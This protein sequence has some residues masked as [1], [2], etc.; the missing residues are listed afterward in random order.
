M[1]SAIAIAYKTPDSLYFTRPEQKKYVRWI[2]SPEYSRANHPSLNT[3]SRIRNGENDCALVWQEGLAPNR[4]IYYTGL[5][6]RNDSIIY[7]IPNTIVGE[8]VG[9]LGD[10]LTNT[11]TTILKAGLWHDNTMPVVQRIDDNLCY[12]Y[13]P[14]NADYNL[15]RVVWVISGLDSS[16]K[17]MQ[18]NI[19]VW[20]DNPG[21]H[22]VNLTFFNRIFS[23]GKDLIQPSL[24]QGS[25]PS[26]DTVEMAYSG[27]S[28]YVLNFV[29]SSGDF[30]I[31]QMACNTYV[32]SVPPILDIDSLSDD[33][34]YN[35][36]SD[37]FSK[38]SYYKGQKPN[39]AAM[40]F[41]PEGKNWALNRRIFEHGDSTPP[42]IMASMDLFARKSTLDNDYV[43]PFFGF[44][45][46]DGKSK[47]SP[48]YTIVENKERALK[49]IFNYN[50]E[51]KQINTDTIFTEWF[52]IGSVNDIDYLDLV[53]GKKSN[54][55]NM[56]IQRKQ[57]LRTYNLNQSDVTE[58]KL[59]N[60]KLKFFNG[61][62][63]EYRII[64]VK[65]SSKV[66]FTPEYMVG[67]V[68]L[69]EESMN[70]DGLFRSIAQTTQL[71]LIDLSD[72]P[73]KPGLNIIA[74][75]NPAN[76]FINVSIINQVDDD[77]ESGI[78]KISL[79]SAIGTKLMEFTLK[80]GETI[81]LPISNFTN[82]FYFLRAEE[83]P[84]HWGDDT[85][86]PAVEKIIISR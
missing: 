73:V 47:I 17:I 10:P 71:E 82:G 27:D 60:Q 56:K 31:R 32:F 12:Y 84:T 2:D 54:Y 63:R 70:Y 6:V 77:K 39:L 50:K 59:I 26:C 20:D 21:N 5:S 8:R 37:I 35:Y 23:Y 65:S 49:I 81:N 9:T 74:V 66:L 30:T 11:D 64:W 33:L 62:N 24:A 43:C 1:D 69:D 72:E 18:Q 79:I 78:I 13:Y 57:D 61:Y 44:E 52:K 38:A 80:N 28:S 25:I 51:K 19:D 4:N 85:A 67:S 7:D 15:D 58:N 16:I 76:E 45:N 42:D 75:P 83:I 68:Q 86:S 36:N 48:L 46:S 22:L 14:G 53:K 34:S 40:P 29:E 55:Y 3:Y 41:M